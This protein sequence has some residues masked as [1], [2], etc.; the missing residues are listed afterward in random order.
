MALKTHK[1]AL[2]ATNVQVAW[3]AQQCGQARFAFNSALADFKAGLAEGVYR[4]FIDLNN[5]W[6]HRKK[7]LCWTA[8]QN[9]RAAVHGVRNLNVF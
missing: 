2:R 7:S 8:A 5:R 3:F 6:N 9:Q 4:S 1:R